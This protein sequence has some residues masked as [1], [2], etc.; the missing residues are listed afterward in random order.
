MVRRYLLE[1]TG[2]MLLYAALLVAANF[3]DDRFHPTG[4]ARMAVA[5]VPMIGA[6]AAAWAIM[7]HIWKLDEMQRR[8]QLD[9]IAISFLATALGTFGW[10]FAEDAG[11]PDLPTFAIWPL[12]AAGWVAG[13][14]IAR[15]RYL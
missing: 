13:L 5:L 10:G 9:A 2:A 1:L 4:A 11:A 6:V 3:I 12:M 15:R 7:R 8:I 14:F